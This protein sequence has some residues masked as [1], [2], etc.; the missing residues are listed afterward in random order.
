[1]KSILF[2]LFV[3]SLFACGNASKLKSDLLILQSKPILLPSNALIT[4]EGKDSVVPNL[5]DSE[6]KYVVYT[7]SSVCTTCKTNKMYLWGKII[8]YAKIFNGRLKFYFIFAPPKGTEQAIKVSFETFQFQYPVLLDTA[9]EFECLNKH[10][11][12]NKQLHTFLLDKNNNVI[13]VGDILS[14]R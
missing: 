13:L 4:V 5:F 9:Y 11:P 10:L 2:F 8:D 7:D 1:M 6:M 3:L 14:S 12:K